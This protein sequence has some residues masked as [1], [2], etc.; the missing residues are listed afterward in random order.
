MPGPMWSAQTSRKVI[1]RLVVEGNLM[2]QSPAHLGSGDGDDLTDMPLLLDPLEGK[3]LLTGATVAG[4]LRSYLRSRERGSLH[5][6]PDLGD[7]NACQRERESSTVRL[8]GGFKGDDEGEQSPLIVDDAL[9]IG[10]GFELRSGV[11]LNSKSRTAAHQ[12]LFD[13]QLWQAGTRFP[14]RFELLIRGDDD[15]D[16]VKRALATALEGF[17]DGS[18]TLGARKRRGYGRATVEGWRVKIYDLTSSEGLLDWI[19]N[20]EKS[21]SSLGIPTTVDVTAALGITDLLDD[22]RSALSIRAVFALN[23]SLLI[24]SGGGR[25]DIGPDMVHL[26]SRQANGIN[27]PILSGT[28]LGGALRARA[29]KIGKTIGEEPRAQE[30]IEGMFGPEV[31]QGV[32]PRASRVTIQ[33]AAVEH[34]KTDLV[35]H[36][37]SIDRFTGGAR[38]AALFNEQPAFATGDTTV[39]LELKLINPRDHEIGLLLLLLKDLWTGDLPL[40]GESCVGRGRLKGRHAAIIG[41]NGNTLRSW[42]IRGNGEVLTVTGDKDGLEQYITRLNSYLSGAEA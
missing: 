26:H 18:I 40:G 22:A 31:Q 39:S 1:S 2:L 10:G 30:L 24:R 29:L 36:R 41:R 20:G 38:E 9:G 17:S 15:V 13:C 21:L 14:L 32:K 25:D 16:M 34:A 4:A 27:A 35:Q 12:A 33:E 6:H 23:G 42:D 3:P 5:T 11:R 7:E 8:F 37:V 28:S 19:K